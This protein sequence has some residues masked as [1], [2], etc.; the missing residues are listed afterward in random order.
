MHTIFVANIREFEDDFATNLKI[1]Q[2]PCL[3]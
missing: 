1:N 2:F 3:L